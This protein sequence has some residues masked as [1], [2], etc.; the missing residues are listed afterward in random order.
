MG[1]TTL[2]SAPALVLPSL[3]LAA[4][5]GCLCLLCAWGVRHFGRRAGESPRKIKALTWLFTSFGVLGSVATYAVDAGQRRE[6]LFEVVLTNP[7]GEPGVQA[8]VLTI[9]VE[10]PGVE[11]VLRVVPKPARFESARGTCRVG[12]RWTAPDGTVHFEG[13][14]AAEPEPIN[15]RA[16][17]FVWDGVAWRFTPRSEGT[18]TL[19]VELD[20]PSVAELLVRVEDP[21]KRDG[22][23]AAGY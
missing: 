20:H 21:S 13:I 19:L 18:H 5:I 14:L 11:H 9:D 22:V 1:P 4:L 15:R 2:E 3:L 17:R 7:V 6:T 16:L 10:D 12:A 8:H 23:R